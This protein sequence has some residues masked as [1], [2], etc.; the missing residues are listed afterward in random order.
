MQTANTILEQLGGRHFIAMTGA[1]NFIGSGDTLRFALPAPRCL[2]AVTLDPSDTYTVR[3]LSRTTGAEQE[4]REGVY[5]DELQR[6]FSA[7]TGLAT[8]L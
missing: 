5:C 1:R 7:L 2:I 6:T 8:R 4:R 3:R